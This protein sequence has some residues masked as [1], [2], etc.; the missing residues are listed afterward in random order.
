GT[1]GPC[2]GHISPEAYEGGPIGLIQEGDIIEI[3]MPERRLELKVSE[4]EL[5]KRRVLFKPVEKE[6]TGYLA[7]YRKMVSSASKG[8]I[9]E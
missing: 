4:E 6:A 2:I 5:E 3:D 8:A 1:R 7:R 9:R